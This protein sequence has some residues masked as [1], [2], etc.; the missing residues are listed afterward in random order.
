MIND[1]IYNQAEALI[2][3]AL[4][5]S[6]PTLDIRPNTPQYDTAVRIFLPIVAEIVSNLNAAEAK[7]AA[8]N[9][10]LLTEAEVAAEA[11]RYFTTLL[12]GG[13]SNGS[14]RLKFK[15]RQ[16]VNLAKSNKLTQSGLIYFPTVAVS[17]AGTD[18]LQDPVQRYYYA[19]LAVIA[20][21]S[22]A[23]Y[24]TGPG[25]RF[26]V[27]AYSGN[28]NFLEAIATTVITGGSAPETAGEVYARIQRNQTT[29]N[30][31]S[32]LSI[33][34][35]LAENFRGVIQRLVVVGHSE[36][37]MRRGLRRIV[38]PVFG[39]ATLALG[40]FTDI[41]IQTPIVRETI[42]FVLAAG[43]TEVDLTGFAPVLKVHGV[44][45]QDHPEIV[46][47][48]AVTG[49]TPELRYSAADDIKL[50][51]D[52]GLVGQT[53]L[54]DISHAPDVQTVQ[55]FCSDDTIRLTCA[56]VLVRFMIPVW[57]SA[58]IYVEGGFGLE[59]QAIAQCNAYLDTLFPGDTLVVSRLTEAI[60]RA[61]VGSVFQDYEVV[62]EVYLPTA[63]N[64]RVELHD[65]KTLRFDE[66]TVM[67][68]NAVG[69]SARI[70]CFINEGIRITAIT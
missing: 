67:G 16:D 13:F 70:A 2:I 37:E 28:A 36:P 14:L 11:N 61:G 8:A 42:A 6:F 38:D 34:A 49:A 52:P 43:Q 65:A 31:V 69:F 21:T 19:D 68:A 7:R 9:W 10:S 35:V 47:F 58:N 27:D 24:D 55:S 39:V 62:G 50:A 4:N 26:T 33:E 64:T 25:A 59:N 60:H 54:V 56:D 23:N 32:A 20:M 3:K 22:G 51:I 18:L 45:V 48:W 57:L 41:Y 53:V 1:V 29:R 40:G 15:A 5:A 17:I 12:P 63:D 46:P 30:L 66:T 44:S